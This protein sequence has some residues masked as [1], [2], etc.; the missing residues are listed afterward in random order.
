MAARR[1]IGVSQIQCILDLFHFSAEANLSSYLLTHD[2][3][4]APWAVYRDSL[5]WGP[6]YKPRCR[7][8]ETRDL[9]PLVTHAMEHGVLREDCR[10]TEVSLDIQYHQVLFFATLM[11][12][13]EAAGEVFHGADEVSRPGMICAL[14]QLAGL[15]AL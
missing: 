12:N 13:L 5:L 9:I 15:R 4:L 14:I 6:R 7:I 1:P 10:N 3:F 11:R 2:T 8:P